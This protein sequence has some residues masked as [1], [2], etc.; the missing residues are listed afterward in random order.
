M[1]DEQC[2]HRTLYFIIFIFEKYIIK[3]IQ[4]CNPF[5]SKRKEPV[6]LGVVTGP[7]I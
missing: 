1:I 4:F 5:F 2:N 6:H 3:Y 7:P